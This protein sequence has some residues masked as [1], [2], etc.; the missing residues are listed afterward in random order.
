[1]PLMSRNTLNFALPESMRA[2]IDARVASGHYG[3]TSEY[4]RDLIR[5]DQAEEAKAR[6]RALIEEGLASGPATPWTENDRAE[7]MTIAGGDIE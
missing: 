7:L 5:K 1:M 3:N 4:I 2:Y 6:L